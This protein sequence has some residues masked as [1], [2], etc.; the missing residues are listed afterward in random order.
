MSGSFVPADAAGF[1]IHLISEVKRLARLVLGLALV[2]L[3]FH[4]HVTERNG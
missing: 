1:S 4:E 2:K 3:L